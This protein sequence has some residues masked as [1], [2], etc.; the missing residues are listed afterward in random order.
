MLKLRIV[1]ICML[2]F[3][4]FGSIAADS[5]LESDKEIKVVVKRSGDL[6]L[7]DVSFTVTATTQEAWNVL[8]DYDRMAQF[9]P[10]VDSSSV[11]ERS[12]NKLKV[13]Q[14]GRSSRGL[15]SFALDYVRE[16]E[17]IPYHEIHSRVISGTLKK[18]DALTQLTPL[19]SGT[20]VTYHS[21]SLPN[22]WIPPGIGPLFIENE[23]R[24]QFE[25]FRNEMLRRKEA[26]KN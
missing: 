9:L 24:K 4:I 10:N 5:T 12:G 1:L 20:R 18:L 23:M 6:L 2:G 11:I 7:I 8:T 22:A 13:A 17:L 19:E 14:K 26:N 25:N 15:L 16:I 3:F 21:E